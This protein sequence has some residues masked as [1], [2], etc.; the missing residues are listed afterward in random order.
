M[1]RVASP[2]LTSPSPGGNSPSPLRWAV[3][4]SGRGSNLQV[5]LD[6]CEL[7][8]V[9]LVISSKLKVAGV[10]KARR[11]GV[12]VVG[13]GHKEPNWDLALQE[14]R[15]NRV[16]HIFLLGFMRIFP[17]HM[18]EPYEGRIFNLHPSLLPEFKGAN[19]FAESFHARRAMGATLHHVTVALDEGRTVAQKPL[20]L[21]RA[22]NEEPS[23][24][25]AGPNSESAAALRFQIAQTLLATTEQRLVRDGITRLT[26][27]D[28]LRFHR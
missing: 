24:T 18:I 22:L 12:R 20:H 28:R 9:S 21:P 5:L 16:T 7:A 3:F 17:A 26:A 1:G 6:Q 25:N 19:G 27:I 14:L 10:G 11:A 15:R 4:I 13:I 2:D 8:P 23:A